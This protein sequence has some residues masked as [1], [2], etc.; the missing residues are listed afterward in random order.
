MNPPAGF[1]ELADHRHPPRRERPGEH[2]AAC[3]RCAEAKPRRGDD[4]LAVKVEPDGGATWYCHRC[5]WTGGLPRRRERPRTDRRPPLA[6]GRPAA[7]ARR[8]APSVRG[9]AVGGPPPDRPRH[10]RAA[11]YL[12][13]RGCALP[14]P[15]GDLALAPG[16]CHPAERARRSRPCS[17]W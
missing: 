9:P 1:L 7:R 3:P 12:A 13:G 16:R 11:R 15:D 14:P 10:R 2:R 8:P 17:P 6:A 4:A 5:G